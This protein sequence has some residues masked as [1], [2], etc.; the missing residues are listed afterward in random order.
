LK[1]E[2]GELVIE[3]LKHQDK[4]P[5]SKFYAA[6]PGPV[7]IGLTASVRE[8]RTPENGPAI[9]RWGAIVEASE[10]VKRTAEWRETDIF[11]SVPRISRPFHGLPSV[12]SLPFPAVNCWAIFNRPLVADWDQSSNQVHP[13]WHLAVSCFDTRLKPHNTAQPSFHGLTLHWRHTQQ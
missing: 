2:T 11:E 8:S 1:T 6:F 12:I 5:L 3:E 9:H 10:S 13:Y 4:K 7:I